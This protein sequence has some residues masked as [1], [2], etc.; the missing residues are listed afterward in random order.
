MEHFRNTLILACC[1]HGD[2]GVKGTQRDLAVLDIP[3]LT[4]YCQKDITAQTLTFYKYE[5]WLKLQSGRS[6]EL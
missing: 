3:P 4:E 1:S 2:H 6:G 5:G